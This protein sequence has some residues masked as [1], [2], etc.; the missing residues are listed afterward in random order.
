[1][2]PQDLIEFTG[3]TGSEV[4]SQARTALDMAESLVATYCRGR[5][6]RGGHWRPG[7]ETVISTVAARILSNPEFIQVRE[8]IGPYQYFRGEGFTGFTIAELSVLNRY[9]KRAV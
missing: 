5:H 8:V 9:R 7:I 2:T 6:A 1:V 4:E 3:A